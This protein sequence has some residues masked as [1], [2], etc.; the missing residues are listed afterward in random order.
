[1]VK[2]DKKTNINQLIALIVESIRSRKGSKIVD[3]DIT[4]LNSSVCSHFLVC[5]AQSSVQVKA[6]AEAIYDQ[7]LDE[8]AKKP[9]HRE[10]H[11]N[12]YWILLDYGEI[13]VHVFQEEA[14]KFY[15]LEELWGDGVQ[16]KY[17]AEKVV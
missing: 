13:I 10:G 6:I 5:E 9:D 14:R 11:Q 2:K 12:G 15:N 8:K 1:M 7:V 16:K 3:I 17:A 4:R